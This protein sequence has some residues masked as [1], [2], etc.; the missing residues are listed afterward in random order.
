LLG[1]LNLCLGMKSTSIKIK[2]ER[3]KSPYAGGMNTMY[4]D[5]FFQLKENK[6]ELNP[7]NREMNLEI[8]KNLQYNQNRP[9][10]RKA[11]RLGSSN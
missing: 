3:F 9:E 8:I 7:L 10:S 11:S 6:K 5:G 1:K 4:G 2:N